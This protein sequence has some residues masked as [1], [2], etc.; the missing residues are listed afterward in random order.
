[1]VSIEMLHGTNAFC[2][3]CRSITE[4]TS[5]PSAHI[6]YIVTGN[7]AGRLRIISAWIDK[8]K[9]WH[10]SAPRLEKRIREAFEVRGVYQAGGTVE[11]PAYFTLRHEPEEANVWYGAGLRRDLKVI[12]VITDLN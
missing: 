12:F 1:M 10:A 5:Q 8:R 2:I 7:R 9:R 4:D 3:P 6:V 11:I